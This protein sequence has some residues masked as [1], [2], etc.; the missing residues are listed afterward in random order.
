MQIA[1]AQK[2]PNLAEFLKHH[3]I[4][5]IQEGH[6]VEN[7]RRSRRILPIVGL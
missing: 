7:S 1:V 5:I 6:E 3:H 4:K 2:G